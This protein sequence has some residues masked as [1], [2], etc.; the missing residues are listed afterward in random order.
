M[1][2]DQNRFQLGPLYLLALG[3]VCISFSAIFVKLIDPALMGP[4]AIGFWRL[5]LGAIILFSIAAIKGQLSMPGIAVV[6]WMFIAAMLFFWDLFFWHRSILYT[7]AGMATILGNTQ[8]LATALLSWLIFKERLSFKFW[9]AAVSAIGGVV[10]LVGVGSLVLFESLY[11]YGIGFGLLTGICYAG[12]IVSLKSIGS[13]K[14]CPDLVTLMAWVSL[15]GSVFMLLTLFIES[16]PIM[17]T[18][19]STWLWLFLLALVAQSFGWW[20]IVSSLVKIEGSRGGLTLLLQPLLTTVWGVI[21][22]GEYLT[23]LQMVGALITLAAIYYGS[24]QKHSQE[25]RPR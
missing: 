17:P 9:V 25:K 22:F 3:A 18:D 21:I 7:G 2:S 14:D 23:P 19:P 13:R 10:L 4:T 11:L 12:Y 24:I 8:V 5:F 20:A 16:S 15:F 6:K 1:K